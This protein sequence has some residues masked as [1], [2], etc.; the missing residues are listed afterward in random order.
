[1]RWP[2]IAVPTLSIGRDPVI[3]KHLGS[4]LDGRVCNRRPRTR[5]C[6]R[7]HGLYGVRWNYGCMLRCGYFR[8]RDRA[9][10]Y[11]P[12]LRRSLSP[13]RPSQSRSLETACPRLELHLR[14]CHRA[15][16]LIR[17]IVGTEAPRRL[18]SR[19]LGRVGRQWRTCAL[20]RIFRNEMDS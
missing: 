9:G 7:R 6:F 13:L 3:S 17:T 5:S 18:I 4:V 15:S 2:P 14:R 20:R 1:M 10:A 12:P 8:L 19:G 11:Q 16:S